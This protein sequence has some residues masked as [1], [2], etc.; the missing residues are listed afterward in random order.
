[1]QDA[2][3]FVVVDV[4]IFVAG[5]V[6]HC[7]QLI[8]DKG[9]GRFLGQL[10]ALEAGIGSLDHGHGD[11]VDMADLLNAF[12]GDGLVDLVA[13]EPGKEGIA[14]KDDRGEQQQL[15]T[16]SKPGHRETPRHLDVLWCHQF[17]NPPLI[18]TGF[19]DIHAS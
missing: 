18:L 17:L 1:M 14:G 6:L 9:L 8:L 16:N 4:V 2:G 12:R 19:P 5:S 7:S 10:T 15:C 11:F 13:R 3:A